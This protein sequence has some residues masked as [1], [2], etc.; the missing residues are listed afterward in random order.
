MWVDLEASDSTDVQSCTDELPFWRMVTIDTRP[1][2][3]ERAE[4][5][6]RPYST[7]DFAWAVE[8]LAATGGRQRVRRGRVVDL[9][10]LPGLVATRFDQPTSLLTLTRHLDELEV[11]VLAGAPFDDAAARMLLRAASTYASGSC[12]RIW[13][14]CS[15]AEFD[16]QRLL[17]QNGFRLCATRPGAI[18][19]V[20]RRVD[21]PLLADL[22]GVPVRDE[23][24]FDQFIN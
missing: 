17:Q 9:A 8:L 12:R 20:R 13:S 5:E 19:A 2:D 22:G 11:S 18:E 3:V 7:E 21:T 15:N 6:I 24:E 1:P 4:P 23:V 16:V 10:V 14:V